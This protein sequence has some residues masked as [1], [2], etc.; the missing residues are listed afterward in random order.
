MLTRLFPLPRCRLWLLSWVV[1]T[2]NSKRSVGAIA[3]L[4]INYSALFVANFKE[5]LLATVS[6]AGSFVLQVPLY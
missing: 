6:L 1:A 2:I 5:Q 3:H 4:C